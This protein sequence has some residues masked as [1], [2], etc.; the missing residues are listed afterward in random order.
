MS[1]ATLASA[2][3]IPDQDN[4]RQSPTSFTKRRNS[5]VTD[6]DP[7]RPRLSGQDETS[8]QSHRLRPSPSKAASTLVENGP[9]EKQPA[10]KGGREEDRKRGQ[11]LFG[12][13]LGTLSQ[14]SS[15]AAQKRR[16]DIEKRQQDK[17]KSQANEYD[18]LKKKSKERRELI[19]KKETP[20]YAREAYYKPWQYRPGD[21]DIIQD[22][23]KEAKESVA[24]EV[25]D[26][27]ARYPS[28]AF[29][30][31]DIE[32][33]SA[34]KDEPKEQAQPT[35]EKT[36]QVTGVQQDLVP[37]EVSIQTEN[38]EGEVRSSDEHAES[39]LE[40]K[41]NTEPAVYEGDQ[42]QHDTHRDD[43]G[44]E[45]VEDNEDTVIY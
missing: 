28:E 8:P 10:R 17:L 3:A 21:E 45:V 31:E 4:Q 27:E 39:A 14:S 36:E 16:A 30:P 9:T 2:V 33:A 35:Q 1:E 20:F 43:D 34:S 15:S 24:R 19:R 23:I 44:G 32:P 38:P 11:R 5:S 18:G 12:G 26:F 29:I 7:K 41:D 37:Q 13:L 22:Q 42:E 40:N 6:H 25:A